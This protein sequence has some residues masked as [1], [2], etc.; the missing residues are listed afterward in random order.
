MNVFSTEFGMFIV[1]KGKVYKYDGTDFCEVEFKDC[2][3]E[4]VANIII[5]DD[6]DPKPGGQ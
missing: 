5:I 1:A 6:P 2:N 4:P 3:G